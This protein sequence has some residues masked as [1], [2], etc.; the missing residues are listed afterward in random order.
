MVFQRNDG[1]T[2]RDGVT[3]PMLLSGAIGLVANTATAGRGN[4]V[5][6]DRAFFAGGRLSR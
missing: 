3:G 1:L 4:L 5:G 6:A 2:L